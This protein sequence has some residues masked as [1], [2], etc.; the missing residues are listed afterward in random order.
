MLELGFSSGDNLFETGDKPSK[1][2]DKLQYLLWI[3][4]AEIIEIERS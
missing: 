4:T 2:G 3:L 1:Y